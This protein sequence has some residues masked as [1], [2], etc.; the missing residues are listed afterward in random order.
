MQQVYG[1]AFLDALLD[2]PRREMACFQLVHATGEA[3]WLKIKGSNNFESTS[4][5]NIEFEP[6]V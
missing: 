5:R 2:R 1:R 3:I 6:C 4:R